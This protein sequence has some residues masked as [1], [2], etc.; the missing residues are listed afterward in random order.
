ML[1]DLE[2]FQA[3]NQLLDLKKPNIF[4]R[5]GYSDIPFLKTPRKSVETH[6][7]F[8]RNILGLN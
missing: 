5:I 2:F 6:S 1:H 3:N 8:F 4:F 7:I